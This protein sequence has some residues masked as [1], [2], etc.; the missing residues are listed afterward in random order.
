MK[1]KHESIKVGQDPTMPAG[2]CL[3]V[4]IADNAILY[5]GRIGGLTEELLDQDGTV[6]I[7][8]PIDFADGENFMKATRH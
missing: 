4:R 5:A 1:P 6:L 2:R 8:H 7:L 3:V